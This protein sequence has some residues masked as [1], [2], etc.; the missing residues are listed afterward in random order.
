M[1]R[2]RGSLAAGETDGLAP[3]G[4]L[5]APGSSVLAARAG[6]G[7]WGRTVRGDGPPASGIESAGMGA[8]LRAARGQVANW[9]REHGG[10]SHGRGGEP[11]GG[12]GAA[13]A[14]EPGSCPHPQPPSLPRG[15][16]RTG[17]QGEGAASPGEDVR[18][19]TPL[20]GPR[21]DPEK[22]PAWG[23]A[24]GSGAGRSRGPGLC[25]GPEPRSPAGA[26]PRRGWVG[27]GRGRRRRWASGAPWARLLT[28]LGVEVGW[29][30]ASWPQQAPHSVL[31]LPS[32]PV[33]RPQAPC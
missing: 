17:F 27:S 5:P 10:E 9:I 19:P 8:E 1:R 29:G 33:G 26:R 14:T 13:G 28:G 23:A 2:G 31:C 3:L 20:P 4:L 11:G 21:C 18:S 15:R 6:A 22:T 24:P 16:R 30:K 25:A 32:P 12:A 7:S